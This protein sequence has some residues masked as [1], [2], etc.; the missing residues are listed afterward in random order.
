MKPGNL[1]RDHR[2][3]AADIGVVGALDEAAD[4][5]P[6]MAV[7]G[8]AQ[9]RRAMPRPARACWPRARRRFPLREI[10]SV[11]RS[12]SMLLM[13]TSPRSG[14]LRVVGQAAGIAAARALVGGG[15]GNRSENRRG[16][17]AAAPPVDQHRLG[18]DAGLAVDDHD[19]GALGREMLVA[20]GEQRPEHRPE[21][22]AA[23]GQHIFK[24]RRML[25]VAR[26]APAGPTRRGR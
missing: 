10:T 18:R 13:T 9:R 12:T 11:A 2:H 21:I 22:A 23:R 16:E 14:E 4:R 26:G 25:V 20:P 5:P 6:L 15:A 8:H 17:R 19:A 3:I 24:A 7:P 1:G